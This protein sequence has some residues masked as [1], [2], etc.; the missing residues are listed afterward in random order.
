MKRL[1]LILLSVFL[2]SGLWAQELLP[3][4]N[5]QY[6]V[7]D[8]NKARFIWDFPENYTAHSQ[9][10]SWSNCEYY[11]LIG[12]PTHINWPCAHR[13]DT[14]DLRYF[15]GWRVTAIEFMPTQDRTDYSIRIWKG[16]E[17]PELCYNFPVGDDTTL[18][19]MNYYPVT[20][21]VFIEEGKQLWIGFNTDDPYGRYPWAVDHGPAMA[22]KGDL[23]WMAGGF[24]SMAGY[25]MNYNLCIRAHIESP[26]GEQK[27]I[28]WDSQQEEDEAITG[29]N[30]YVNGDLVEAIEGSI[31]TYYDLTCIS[32]WN[33]L[34]FTVKAVYGEQESEPASISTTWPDDDR[35]YWKV[36]TQ[37]DDYVVDDDGNITI[38]SAEGL[39][40]L[41]SVV[42]GYNCQPGKMLATKTINITDDIDL[43]D[44]IWTAIDFTNYYY[45]EQYFAANIRGNG[46]TISG[47]HGSYSFINNFKGSLKD[48]NFEDCEFIDTEGEHPIGGI[49]CYLTLSST[50]YPLIDNCHVRNTTVQ[51]EGVCGGLVGSTNQSTIRNCSF[52]DGT[53]TTYGSYCGGLLGKDDSYS[54]VENSYF[55]GNLMDLSGDTAQMGGIVG[56][57]YNHKSIKNC[58]AVLM[59]SNVPENVAGIISDLGTVRAIYN[60]YSMFPHEICFDTLASEVNCA[61]FDGG[62]NDWQL[63]EPVLVGE[64]QTDDLLTALETWVT[65]QTNLNRYYE[66]VEDTEMINHGFPI[67]GEKYDDI[68]EKPSDNEALL[69][70]NP[71]TGLLTIT[72]DDFSHAEVYDLMGRRIKQSQQPTLDIHA[73]P[74]GIYVVKVFNNTGNIIIRKVIKN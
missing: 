9:S 1:V 5:L 41:I 71:T 34:E 60:C 49:V 73:L 24:E 58:Y 70:P 26:E 48:L 39:A 3:V 31:P 17:A 6:E 53:V 67:F 46:F 50:N 64:Q 13:F 29:Y 27:V 32:D 21:D 51:S 57:S 65:I 72:M 44:G 23:M 4:T 62:G 47:L 14:Y 68:K 8:S 74:Q 2:T 63:L 42:N 10:I 55:V 40:W 45:G 28:G 56:Y 59:E 30:L 61:M 19:Q 69:Y 12:S 66:W 54:S 7:K 52:T 16:E 38:S 22:G 20:E 11:D 37:P 18:F 36:I 35:W 43:S 15:V 25:N 33:D